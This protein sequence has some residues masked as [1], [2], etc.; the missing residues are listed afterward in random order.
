MSASDERTLVSVF[1]AQAEQR[2]S[3]PALRSKQGGVWRARTWGQWLEESRS[4]ARAL[5]SAGLEPGDRVA[6][7]AETSERWIICD[8]AALLA[9]LVS[10]PVYPTLP[11]ADVAYVLEHSKARVLF[12]DDAR[13]LGRI[14]SGDAIETLTRLDAIV[15]LSSDAPYTDTRLERRVHGYDAWRARGESQDESVLDARIGARRASDLATIV[16][17]SGTTGRQKGVELTDAH[18]LFE[19]DQLLAVFDMTPSD[20]QLMLLPLDH[21]FGRLLV[22][23]QL[24]VGGVTAFVESLA[25]ALDNAV[26]IS[27]TFIASVPRFFE[28]V[29]AVADQKAHAEGRVKSKVFDWALSIGKRRRS[30]SDPLSSV[31]QRYA[32]RLVFRKL[33]ARFGNRLRFAISGGAP[34]SEELCRWYQAVGIDLLEGY[35]LTETTGALSV[36]RPGAARPGTVGTPIPGVE[37]KIGFGGEVL[38]RGPSVMRGYHRDDDATREAIDADGWL[39]TGDVGELDRDGYLKITDRKKDM[40]VTAGGKKVAPGRLEQLLTDSPWIAHAIIYGD[41]RPFVV[42]AIALDVDAM[43]RYADD[44]GKSADLARLARDEEVVARIGI[45]VER[46]N[47]KLAPF[48]QVK[49]FVILPRA[50]SVEADELTPT[51]KVR[52]VVVSKRYEALFAELYGPSA[53]PPSMR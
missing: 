33:R 15:T 7:S 4:I 19:I 29:Y 49:R 42:A 11:A 28:K 45:E 46:T 14:Y 50:L 48:E 13:R 3:S 26:E 40:I 34:L 16:Y 39:H 2:A 47:R 36:N 44:S 37:V 51:L 5:V 20:E 38:V 52:R 6:I 9:G 22:F 53:P 43:R 18:F 1:L 32:D 23:A 21:I 8:M 24:V 10:V 25:Y 31:Q 41:G 27:P 17:T 35:G 12:V 30:S